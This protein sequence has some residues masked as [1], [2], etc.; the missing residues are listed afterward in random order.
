[1]TVNELKSSV[2]KKD[3]HKSSC[4]EMFSPAFTITETTTTATA[5]SGVLLVNFRKTKS[6]VFNQSGLVV[7][8]D[9]KYIL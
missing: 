3:R 8:Q 9:L 5:A 7:F 2:G 4:L 6:P 1:M